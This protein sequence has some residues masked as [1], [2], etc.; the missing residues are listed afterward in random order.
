MVAQADRRA[1]TR[2]RLLDAAMACLVD[3]GYAGFTTTEVVQRSGCSRGALFDHFP[4]KDDLLAATIEH[5]FDDLRADYE[6]RF[7]RLRPAHRTIGRALR[8]LKELFDDPRLLAAYELYTAARTSPPLADALE[9][10]VNAHNKAIYDLAATLPIELEAA[11]PDGTDLHAA[12]A[13]A[14]YSLQGLAVQGLAQDV[15]AER[16]TVLRALEALASEA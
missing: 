5:L 15:S 1:A 14:I 6:A 7:R 4:A 13:L 2:T 10:V 3:Q 11:S 16:Q 9:P 12:V 8:L